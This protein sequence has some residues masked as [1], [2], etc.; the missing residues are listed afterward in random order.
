MVVAIVKMGSILIVVVD[1]H[2]SVSNDLAYIIDS[3]VA[4]TKLTSSL[5]NLMYFILKL[6]ISATSPIDRVTKTHD[7]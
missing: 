6:Q 7:Y 4:T 3:I 2:I 1:L 5:I